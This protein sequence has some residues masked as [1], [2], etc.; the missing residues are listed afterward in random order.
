MELWLWLDVRPEPAVPTL[1]LKPLRPALP[2]LHSRLPQS[3]CKIVLLMAL[4]ALH[5]HVADVL[6]VV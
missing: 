1:S 3:S 4:E 2:P 6:C 5:N